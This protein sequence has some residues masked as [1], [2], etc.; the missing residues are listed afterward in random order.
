MYGYFYIHESYLKTFLNVKSKYTDHSLWDVNGWDIPCGFCSICFDIKQCSVSKLLLP[1]VAMNAAG[2]CYM[3]AM[4]SNR[5]TMTN[6]E[7]V[8]LQSKSNVK[9]I[10]VLLFIP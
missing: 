3:F 1:N 5:T 10:A 9:L 4:S 6:K 7:A 8:G 2:V